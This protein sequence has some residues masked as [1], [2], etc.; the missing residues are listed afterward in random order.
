MTA[1]RT[2]ACITSTCLA[3]LALGLQ[4]V[5]AESG[6]ATGVP[7]HGGIAQRAQIDFRIVVPAHVKLETVAQPEAVEVR[8]EDIRRG[9]VDVGASTLLRITH[10]TRGGLR[11]ALHLRADWIDRIDVHLLG[12]TLTLRHDPHGALMQVPTAATESVPVHF[13]LHLNERAASGR[14][15]WPVTLNLSPERL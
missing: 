4:P 1:N 14:M 7:G 10:N 8:A 13:R 2:A 9:Y 12:Q 5:R 15:R 6:F 3:S 11:L